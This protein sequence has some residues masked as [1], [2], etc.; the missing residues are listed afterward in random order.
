VM[1]VTYV[2]KTNFGPKLRA[3]ELVEPR[4]SS[5]NQTPGPDDEQA[6][7]YRETPL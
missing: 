4:D 2:C 7:S 3:S 6:R 5:H 1:K